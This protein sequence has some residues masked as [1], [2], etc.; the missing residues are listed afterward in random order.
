MQDLSINTFSERLA[1]LP[2]DE[3]YIFLQDQA[4]RFEGL[5]VPKDQQSELNKLTRYAKSFIWF[6]N[7][8]GQAR[9][10]EVDNDDDY[11]LMRSTYKAIMLNAPSAKGRVSGT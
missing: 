8:G 11:A 3:V 2:F 9:P 1:K 10:G 6:I 4:N 5:K 7:S